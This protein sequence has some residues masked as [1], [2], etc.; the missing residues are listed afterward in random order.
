MANYKL[1]NKIHEYDLEVGASY[2][3]LPFY[4]ANIQVAADGDSTNIS[5]LSVNMGGDYYYHL[6]D[7]VSFGGNLRLYLNTLALEHPR[8]AQMDLSTSTQFDIGLRYSISRD[9]NSHIRYGY[10]SDS[11]IFDGD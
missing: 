9:I 3:S 1:G 11:L 10:L 4:D 8:D 7:S 2:R 5:F 6:N